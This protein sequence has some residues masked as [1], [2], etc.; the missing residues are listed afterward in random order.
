MWNRGHKR[1][2]TIRLQST[3]IVNLFSMFC[4]SL[5]TVGL[6]TGVGVLYA[7]CMMTSSNGKFSALLA[8]CAGNSQI[9][10]EFPSQRPVTRRFDVF[11]Y[12]R[13]TKRLRKQSRGLWFEMPSRSSWRHCNGM[14][15]S[16]RSIYDQMYRTND[17]DSICKIRWYKRYL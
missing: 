15:W 5:K 16:V 14:D 17:L 9:T 7:E 12:L 1:L 3:Q 10:G 2:C 13:L 11:V 8:L 6:W 4:I